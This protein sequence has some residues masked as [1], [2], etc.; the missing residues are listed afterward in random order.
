LRVFEKREDGL[1]QCRAWRL[2]ASIDWIAGQVATADAEWTRASEF[3]RRAG[4]ERELFEILVWQASAALLGPTPVEAAISRCMEIGDQVQGSPVALGKTLHP[5][6][7][8]HAMSGEFDIARS[9]ADKGSAILG[10]FGAVTALGVAQH[11]ASVEMLAGHP[12]LAE[13]RLR[14]AYD[15]LD[16]MGERALL[17]TTAA[18]LAEAV[19][20]QGRF[21]EAER[22]GRASREAAAPDDLSAQV[23]WRGIQAKIFAQKGRND[24]AEELARE[25]VE[26]LAQTDFLDQ[27]G[28]ALLDLAEVLRANGQVVEA[29]AAVRAGLELYEQKGNRASAERARSKLRGE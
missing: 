10:E 22:Y 28:D 1:G 16:E 4:E 15:R 26:L 24:E 11:E 7:A 29:E 12:A 23:G 2:K 13:K 14:W 25:A 27:R 6:A 9:I 18:M 19:Y 17:A 21:E 3:A 5:L 20:A 8:L